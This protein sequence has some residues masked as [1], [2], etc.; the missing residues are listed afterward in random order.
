M[1]IEVSTRSFNFDQD[2]VA[3]RR[4]QAVVHTPAVNGVFAVD[5]FGVKRIPPERIDDG[6]Y[7]HLACGLFRALPEVDYTDSCDEIL[8]S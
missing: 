5:F 4:S 6:I 3:A 7:C 2:K 8:E 1:V